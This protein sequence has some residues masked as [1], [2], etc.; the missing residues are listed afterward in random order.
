[1]STSEERVVAALRASL[2]ENERLRRHNDEL[3]RTATEPI[4]IIGMACRFPGDVTTPEQLWELVAAGAD[5]V[6]PFP[7]DRGWDTT[8]EAS[9]ATTHQGGFV[10]TAADFDAG[11][12][13]VSPR[14]ALAMDPQQ[15]LILETSWEAL[16]HAGLAP[17]SV[18][19]SRTGVYVGCS[20]QN[21]GAVSGDDLPEGIGGHLLTGNAASVVSGRVSYVL[22]LEGP[23]VTVD[24]ACSSSLVALHLAV[25]ALRAGECD[26][27]LAG[28]VTVMSTPDVFTEFA[29][30]GGLAGDG[31]CKAFADAADGTGWGEGAGVL[32]VE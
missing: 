7:A 3:V 22:G 27:A 10:T 19:G 12:F 30:Q 14:E 13:G 32:L 6:T 17:T 24:T 4:A 15:R 23:A 8:G 5:A 20:N 9:M 2:T 28:G 11:F 29:R 21:Y 18:R 16:E 1:M 25:Q 26:L 31:R